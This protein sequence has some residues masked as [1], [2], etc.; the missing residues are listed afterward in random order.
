MVAR[1]KIGW[2][3]AAATRREGAIVEGHHVPQQQRPVVEEHDPMGPAVVELV[4]EEAEQEVVPVLAGARLGLGAKH[5]H[6]VLW[7]VR[8]SSIEEEWKKEL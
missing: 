8:P 5:H 4:L 6:H 3:G 7:A 2:V 1:S